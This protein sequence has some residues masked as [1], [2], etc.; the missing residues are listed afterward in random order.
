MLLS[1]G[2]PLRRRMIRTGLREVLWTHKAPRLS[3]RRGCH[4][5][6]DN[7]WPVFVTWRRVQ[8]LSTS[9]CFL[10][11]VLSLIKNSNL[12]YLNMYQLT[13]SSMSWIEDLL[14]D[15]FKKCLHFLNGSLREG[16]SQ[17]KSIQHN[18]EL[19]LLLLG[20]CKEGI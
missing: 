18:G 16:G 9:S 8:W 19:L 17:N 20:I 10:F 3:G 5:S 1:L 12:H 7:A 13:N 14:F 11:W 15:L 6:D 4:T 2:L